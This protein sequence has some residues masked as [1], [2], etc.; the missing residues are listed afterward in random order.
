MEILN[1]FFGNLWHFIGLLLLLTVI[2]E[3]ILRL[4]LIIKIK[5]LKASDLSDTETEDTES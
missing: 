3:T 4:A 5:N 1:F 2:S